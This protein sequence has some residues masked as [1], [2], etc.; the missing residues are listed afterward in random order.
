MGSAERFPIEPGR[1]AVD[2]ERLPVA[3][4]LEIG[5]TRI[6]LG[7][8]VV[9]PL[10]LVVK[11][12]LPERVRVSARGPFGARTTGGARAACGLGFH[13]V[14]DG[15]HDARTFVH[16]M[17]EAKLL[18]HDALH[19]R[20]GFLDLGFQVVQ[21]VV[22]QHVQLSKDGEFLVAVIRLPD[23]LAKA[24]RV[25]VRLDVLAQHVSVVIVRGFYGHTFSFV[26]LP[27]AV[28]ASRFANDSF[29][30]SGI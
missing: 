13:G 28:M 3:L 9:V 2:P 7:A 1:R 4:A 23:L 22:R 8:A 11:Q 27:L 25:R 30:S 18:K 24:D 15:L 14:L 19:E 5:T 26:R 16:A 10:L 6:R 20:G 17:H 29:Q 21:R 12:I